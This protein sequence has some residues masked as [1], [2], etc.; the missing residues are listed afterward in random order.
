[1]EPKLLETCDIWWQGPSFLSGNENYWPNG[2]DEPL[3][4]PEVRII[5]QN[6]PKDFDLLNKYSSCVTLQRLVGFS[7]TQLGRKTKVFWEN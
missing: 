1:M 7:I 4:L 5:K 2:V 3:D 6:F